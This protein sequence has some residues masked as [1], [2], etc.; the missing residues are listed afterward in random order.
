MP[1]LAL[2]LSP[3]T[4]LQGWAWLEKTHQFGMEVGV[5]RGTYAVSVGY[6]SMYMWE[7]AATPDEALTTSSYYRLYNLTL[8][9]DAGS[10]CGIGTTIR[11]RPTF[12]GIPL[13]DLE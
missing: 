8:Y 2:H 1:F 3:A 7:N 12:M 13:N 5:R 10:L 9:R 11:H 6:G 4:Y